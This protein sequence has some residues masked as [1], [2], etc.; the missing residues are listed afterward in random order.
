MNRALETALL[1]CLMSAPARAQEDDNW[2]FR[3]TPY[4][5][6][7]GMSGD[8]AVGGNQA[9]FDASF[10]DVWERFDF[11]AMLT[12]AARKGRWGLGADMMYT[13]LGADGPIATPFA[14]DSFDF[15]SK[16]FILNPEVSYRLT[17]PGNAA[18]DVSAGVRWWQ[19]RNRLTITNA[20]ATVADAEKS[21]GWVDPIVAAQGTADLGEHFFGIARGD[22]GGFGVGSDLTWQ[23]FGGLGLRF[24]TAGSGL[25]VGYRYL[26]V[27]F[28]DSDNGFL[29]NL[30]M[31]GPLVGFRF[32]L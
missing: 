25:L 19:V 31:H 1:L 26:D 4:L 32:A 21:K 5:F 10:S 8:V 9:S 24:G 30:G 15:D 13:D 6:L 27:D 28:E 22:I 23:A 29:F 20:G 18:L 16:V 11:G 17:R 3:L 14:S 12:F 7:A 2:R